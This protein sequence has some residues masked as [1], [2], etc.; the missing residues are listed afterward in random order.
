MAI[1]Q[2]YIYLVCLKCNCLLF[3]VPLKAI[4]GRLYVRVA[5]HVYSEMKDI[6]RLAQAIKDIKKR[7]S[8]K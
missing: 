8:N 5:V 2:V 1:G 4:A 3:Q 6:E 7:N